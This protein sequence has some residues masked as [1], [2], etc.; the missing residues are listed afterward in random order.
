M[1]FGGAT[2]EAAD[3]V[4]IID[5]ARDGGVNFID[6]AEQ[7]TPAARASA[8]PG[9][10]SAAHR[11]WWVLATKIA[12]PHRRRGRTRSGLSRRQCLHRRGREPEARLGVD[13]IDVLY[14]HK[15][16]HKTP[17]ERGGARDGRPGPQRSHP[18]TSA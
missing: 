4:R 1:M 3:S 13:T 12:N 16:D 6:T 10:P 2:D 15:E 7:P 14:L 18:A 5:R 17:L 11:E 9:G 8:S